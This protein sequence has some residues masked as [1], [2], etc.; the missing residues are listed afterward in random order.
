MDKD[1]NYIQLRN[2][3]GRIEANSS[4]GSNVYKAIKEGVKEFKEYGI[5]NDNHRYFICL[6]S[7]IGN[8]DSNRISKLDV[9]KLLKQFNINLIVFGFGLDYYS[10]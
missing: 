6:T 1:K 4:A 9:I 7:E 10:Q 3:I 2:Q 5:D 8:Q